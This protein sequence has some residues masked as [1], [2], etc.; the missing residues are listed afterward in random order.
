[1]KDAAIKTGTIKRSKSWLP[2][3]LFSTLNLQLLIEKMKRSLSWAMG[4]PKTNILLNNQ[5]KQVVLNVLHRNTEVVS[6]QNCDSIT[7]RVIE[8][9]LKL[10]CKNKTVFIN[11]GNDLT[12]NDKVEYTLSNREETAY[13]L[14]MVN[15]N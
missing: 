12:L 5:K 1:M 7:L 9:R 8:G 3:P 13:L 4:E 15:K 2:I 6:V 14:T 10:E 11:K